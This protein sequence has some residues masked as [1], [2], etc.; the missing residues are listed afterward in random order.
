MLRRIHPAV[1][2]SVRPDLE[3]LAKLHP[4]LPNVLPFV[5]IALV[6]VF[7]VGR[8]FIGSVFTE[9]IPFMVLA[10]AL[11]IVAPAAGVFLILLHGVADIARALLDP[12]ATYA[13]YGP[14]GTIA[15]RLISTYLLWLLVVEIGVIARTV[16]WVVMSSDR[17]AN[18]GLRQ[19]WAVASTAIA[20]GLM[21]WIW[22][23]AAGMLIRPVFTW[24]GLGSPTYIAIANLQVDGMILVIASA[25]VAAAMA[26]M[27]LGRAI[28]E[29]PGEVAF[30]EFEDF[31]LDQFQDQPAGGGLDLI[32]QLVRHILA[33]FVLGGLISGFLDIV[34]LAGVSLASGPIADRVLKRTQLRRLLAGVPWILRF[35]AGFG[36]TYVVGVIVTAVY[37][38][39]LAGSE[40][41]PLIITVAIGLIVFQILLS[42][43]PAE[44]EDE[45]EDEDETASD[46]P[47]VSVGGAVGAALLFFAVGAMLQLAF[48]AAALADNCSGLFDCNSVTTAAAAAA[49]GAAGAA[50]AAAANRKPPKPK[51]RRK[52]KKPQQEDEKA[53]TPPPPPPAEPGDPDYQLPPD[54]REPPPPPPAEP[55]DPDYV[56]PPPPPP[57]EPG[58]PDYDR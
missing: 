26:F 43:M 54:D 3:L 38:Q 5:A 1:A 33:V 42:D 58:D 44:D 47:G 29:R 8:L 55:G 2:G 49:A 48:P 10:A 4:Q 56:E 20:V 27:R 50:A 34:I 9:S 11:G 23:Q 31:D 15:G 35:V 40:F 45:D 52:K 18:Q 22:T 17:P 51:K 13:V 32:G 7:T 19:L 53:P 30:E 41:F 12:Y 24:S 36:L 14:I 46:E 37:Y 6:A 16:P 25:A 39:P 57:A 28:A 21:T